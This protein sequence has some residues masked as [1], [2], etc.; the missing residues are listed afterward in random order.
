MAADL[1]GS[2]RADVLLDFAPG[3]TVLFQGLK[4]K[5]V[6][7]ISPALALF[8]QVVRPPGLHSSSSRSPLPMECRCTT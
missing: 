2:L 7:G 5:R 3:S 6:L 8:A 1:H 4:K